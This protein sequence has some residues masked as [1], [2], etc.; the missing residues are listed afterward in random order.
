M[1]V[2]RIRRDADA[3][4]REWLIEMLG[5]LVDREDDDGAPGLE[6]SPAARYLY[7]CYPT[8]PLLLPLTISYQYLLRIIF[9]FGGDVLLGVIT[10]IRAAGAERKSLTPSSQ[11]RAGR[12]TVYVA[13]I[14]SDSEDDLDFIFSSLPIHGINSIPAGPRKKPV[15]PSLRPSYTDMDDMLPDLE[16]VSDDEDEDDPNV[17]ADDEGDGEPNDDPDDLEELTGLWDNGVYADA[18]RSF[19]ATILS[20]R[21][22]QDLP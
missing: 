19:C 2:L 3:V 18:F 4:T 13:T 7:V 16:P 11:A 1:Y 10:R 12:L 8:S 15:E 17:Q 9:V 21:L 6:I 5:E 20:L 14:S 22:L